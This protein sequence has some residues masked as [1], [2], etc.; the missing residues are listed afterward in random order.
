VLVTALVD[1]L[2]TYINSVVGILDN[3]P[4]MSWVAPPN[5]NPRSLKAMGNIRSW[6]ETC[7]IHHNHGIPVD[8]PCSGPLVL[9]NRLLHIDGEL[10][11]IILIQAS[12]SSAQYAV[13]SYCWGKAGIRQMR[14]LK[15]NVKL[16]ERGIPIASLPKTLQDAVTVASQ[17]RITYIWIDALCI[18]QDDAEDM[19]KELA[20]MPKIYENGAITILAG[21]A[22]DSNNGFLDQ[23]KRKSHRYS[24]T[25]R[26]ETGRMEKVLLEP[27]IEEDWQVN[28]VMEG[29]KYIFAPDP[30]SKRGWILQEV[31]L[32]PRLLYFSPLQTIFHCATS[33]SA[34]GGLPEYAFKHRFVFQSLFS[35]SDTSKDVQ[36]TLDQWNNIVANYSNLGLSF[37]SDKL[38][39]ISAVAQAFHAAHSPISEPQPLYLAGIW[40]NT[41]PFGLL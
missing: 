16:H 31:L 12:L 17:L 34:D 33:L 41:L 19:Q 1:F 14:T 10:G 8:A 26:H 36:Y 40:R 37:S 25:L 18:V 3:S 20:K 9:P 29:K 22:A 2:H 38:P 5:L 7:A 13:L 24:I 15:E 32:S 11:K 28:D 6:F 23:R 21:D 4:V 30:V 35:S 27:H 39:A